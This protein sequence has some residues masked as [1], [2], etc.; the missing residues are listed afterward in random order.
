VSAKRT[1]RAKEDKPPKSVAIAE[2][3]AQ[4]VSGI[5][6][7]EDAI[8]LSAYFKWI[9]AGRPAGDGVIFWLDAERELLQ[10]M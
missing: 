1:T 6:A 3:G 10:G 9:V 4:A 5:V 8:R 7:P 2:G